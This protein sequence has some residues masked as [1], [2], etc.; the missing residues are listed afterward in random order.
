MIESLYKILNLVLGNSLN[1]FFQVVADLKFH[2][3]CFS[4]GSCEQFLGEEDNYV[5]LERHRLVWY[6]KIACIL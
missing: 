6:V 2:T 5:L 4:C 3:E 1:I